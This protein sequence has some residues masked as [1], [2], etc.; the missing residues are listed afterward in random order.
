MKLQY[1]YE[2]KVCPVSQTEKL[3]FFPHTHTEEKY[4]LG[5]WS[6]KA[7]CVLFFVNEHMSML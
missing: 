7:N 2:K 5:L 1:V 4:I 3:F 6:S